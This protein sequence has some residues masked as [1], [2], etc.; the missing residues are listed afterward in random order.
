MRRETR[1]KRSLFSES[2]PADLP[3]AVTPSSARKDL[4]HPQAGRESASFGNKDFDISMLN[5]Y[6]AVIL[7]RIF[8]VEYLF[9]DKEG[10]FP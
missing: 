9:G 2:R 8:A 6:I 10:E 4:V 1:R 3:A 7:A 5:R